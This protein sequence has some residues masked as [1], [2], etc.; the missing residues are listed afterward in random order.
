MK[1]FKLDTTCLM[2]GS[3]RMEILQDDQIA[4]KDCRTIFIASP[5]TDEEMIEWFCD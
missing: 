4:C 1:K 5:I 3:K 2:C